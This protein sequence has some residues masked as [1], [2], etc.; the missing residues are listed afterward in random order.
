M[1]QDR[2][3][4][5][6]IRDEPGDDLH[7]LD[8]ADWLDD[9]GQWPRADFIRAQVRLAALPE[10]DPARDP[11]EDEADDLLAEHEPAWVGRLAELVLQWDWQ[12][13]FVER[14]TVWADTLLTHGEELFELAPLREVRLLLEAGDT[15]RLAAWP[16]LDRLETIDLSRDTRESF[17]R[18]EYQRDQPLQMLLVSPHL[19]RLRNLRLRGHGIEGPLVQTLIERGLLGQLRELDLAH[20][21]P[22]GD[23]AARLLAGAKSPALESLDVQS[24]NLTAGG[25]R[26][27]LGARGLPA[28]TNLG[29]N[30][31]V[32]FPRGLTAETFEREWATAPLAAQLTALR[33]SACPLDAA[34]LVGLL[35][36]PGLARLTHLELWGCRLDAA[37]GERLAECAN[38]SGL[39]SLHLGNNLLRDTGARAL[40]ASAHL[41]R[42]TALRL[43]G[44]G[45]GGP[46]VR[47]LV[48]APA[49]AG[50]LELDLS[51]NYV[52]PT[53]VEA[54][55][56]G[57]EVRRLRRLDLSDAHL[58][59]E[60]GRRLAAARCLA[61]LRVL[62]LGNNSRLG[63]EGVKALAGSAS[64]ARLRELSL[65]SCGLDAVGVQ[66]LV[67]S[68]H[69][70]RVARLELRNTYIRQR[71]K[72]RLELRFGPRTA[73]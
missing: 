68:P 55:A 5:E 64:L 7:R 48:S 69:L 57:T 59:A 61:R 29:V 39:R 51:G 67:E 33:F 63:D 30:A 35:A 47:A 15:A 28:L 56:G 26:A 43:G 14:V 2:V 27:L 54:L 42:L 3:F 32:L 62:R 53:G 44:N 71:D 31:G 19:G 52:G 41:A 70:N 17:F 16:L 13:G 6:A 50:L 11:L 49:L 8:F 10:D 72:D 45:I 34:A 66:A 22:L 18:G 20:N 25:V 9:H 1:E 73:F 38:L 60:C 58:D 46:G 37:A 23:R 40:A 24:T 21:A 4:H 12:R 65:D 36:W